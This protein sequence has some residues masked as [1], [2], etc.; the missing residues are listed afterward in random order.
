M[1]LKV[2][3]FPYRVIRYV[4]GVLRFGSFGWYTS[5]KKP[6]LINNSRN[7][8]LENKSRVGKYSWLAA[9]KVISKNS[10]L[11]LKQG[12]VIGDFAHIFA[13]QEIVI[14]KDVLIANFVYIADNVH[15]YED[16]NI[17]IIKQ[18]IVQ[19]KPVHI[20]EGSWIGEHVSIIGS[21][22]GKHCVIGANSVVTRDIPDYSIAVG[23]PAKVIKRYN[24]KT[25]KWEK[26]E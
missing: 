21:N 11:I 2:F 4:W 18:P 12:C 8:F 9:S 15:G 26:V 7:I 25:Q 19:K 3:L 20:G 23:S 6:L 14:E 22:I 5:I 13:S 24:F 16:I 17:P 1:I 10:K